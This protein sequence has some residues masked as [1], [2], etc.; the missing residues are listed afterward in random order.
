MKGPDSKQISKFLESGHLNN[1][2]TSI[3]SLSEPVTETMIRLNL[4][5]LNEFDKNPRRS[6]NKEYDLLKASLLKTGADKVVLVVTR[7]LPISHKFCL[8]VNSDTGIRGRG[9]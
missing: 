8:D 6:L 1:S 3:D 9:A 7:R 4:D 5:Q 2:E